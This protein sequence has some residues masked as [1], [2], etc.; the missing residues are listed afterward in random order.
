HTRSK[1]DWSSDVCSSDLGRAPCPPRS[2]WASP[3]TYLPRPNPEGR[4][5]TGVPGSLV[6][7]FEPTVEIRR[8]Q[9]PTAPPR[10]SPASSWRRGRSEERRVGKERRARGSG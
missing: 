7:E 9:A 2:A 6:G 3:C 4:L 1:R 8:W 5:A 10:P